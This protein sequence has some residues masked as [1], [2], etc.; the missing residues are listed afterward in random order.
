MPKPFLPEGASPVPTV[1]LRSGDVI[2]TTIS[3]GRQGGI[4]MTFAVK[5]TETCDLHHGCVSVTLAPCCS[6]FAPFRVCWPIDTVH[7]V[8]RHNRAPPRVVS[9]ERKEERP[10]PFRP[11]RYG[12]DVETR[13]LRILLDE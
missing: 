13:A 4:K 1:A 11:S 9:P 6:G 10:A 12:T 8:E 3:T 7:T 2:H 5:R